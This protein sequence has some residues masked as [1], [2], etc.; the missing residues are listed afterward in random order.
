MYK[1]SSSQFIRTTTGKIRTRHLFFKKKKMG[2][3]PCNTERPL[4]GMELWQKETQKILMHTG[5]LLKKNPV[6]RCL[7]ILDFT[8]LDFKAI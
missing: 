3:T 6:T 7:L 8:L 5:N 1:S 4:R 2:F